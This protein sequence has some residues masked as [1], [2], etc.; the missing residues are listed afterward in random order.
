MNLLF[1]INSNNQS[2]GGAVFAPIII[3]DVIIDFY[4]LKIDT[5]FFKE[6][7]FWNLIFNFNIS[8]PKYKKLNNKSNSFEFDSISQLLIWLFKNLKNYNLLVFHG[9]WSY[10]Y[11]IGSIFCILARKPFCFHPH[12]S[13]DPFDFNKKKR[14]IKSF[15]GFLIYKFIFSFSSGLIFTSYLELVRSKTFNVKISKYIGCLT[16]PNELS[17]KEINF[18][19]INKLKHE[20]KIF[21]N[22]KILLFLSRIDSKKGLDILLKSL[23]LIKSNSDNYVLLIAGVGEKNYSNYINNLIKSLNLDSEVR[24]LGHIEN[25]KK[26]EIMKISD[27]FILPS[28]NE[29]FGIAIVE[30]LQNNLPVLITKDVYIHEAIIRESAGYLCNRDPHDLADLIQ[31]ILNNPRY[32]KTNQYLNCFN[33]NFSRQKCAQENFNIYSEIIKSYAK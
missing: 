19:R 22:K 17:N 28:L 32:N 11:V 33:K 26:I 9:I 24:L 21:K 3:R 25:D 23:A 14:L 4:N 6:K 16:S 13:L 1:F 15:L 12:G 5:L 30:A 20:Y 29:N 10:I 27:L 8:K 2:K 7:R 31:K 18:E